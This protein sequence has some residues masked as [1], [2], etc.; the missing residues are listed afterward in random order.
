M[1]LSVAVL[2]LLVSISACGKA[3]SGLER[4][5][6]AG[7]LR[8]A[9]DPSFPPFESVSGAGEIEGLDVDLARAVAGHLGVQAH[10]VTTGYDALYD[11]LTVGRADIIVSALYPDPAR[12]QAFHFSHAYF[13]AGYVLVV[14][15]GSAVTAMEDLEGRLVACVFG[16]TGHG[17]LLQ[18]VRLMALPPVVL[19]VDDPITLTQLLHTGE[20]DAVVTDRVSALVAAGEDP[21]LR[22]LDPPI[23]NEPYVIA[24]RK[25]DSSLAQAVDAALELL[26]ADGTLD[27]LVAT[28]MKP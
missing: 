15:E 22:I 19:T 8:V 26:A 21:T 12:S 25:E 6:A 23:T 1:A 20:A 24:V 10:F 5:Q 4:V 28:W 27:E 7:M 17:E 11:A 2:L 16:T 14:S 13:D 3:S 18:R 9:I